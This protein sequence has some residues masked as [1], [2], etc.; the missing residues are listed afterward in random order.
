MHHSV[1]L[2]EKQYDECYLV[3]NAFY[4]A[5]SRWAASDDVTA[6]TSPASRRANCHRLKR[7]DAYKNAYKT[8][9]ED[10]SLGETQ[11]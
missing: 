7:S 3:E 4:R 5:C 1:A 2:P 6:L 10:S 8:L 9:Y 11:A